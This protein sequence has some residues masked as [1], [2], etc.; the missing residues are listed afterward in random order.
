[1]I[2][3][4]KYKNPNKYIINNNKFIRD[5]ENMY[6]NITDPWCQKQNFEKSEDFIFCL[7]GLLNYINKKKSKISVLDVGAADGILKK[8]LKKKFKYVGTDIHKKKLNDVIY[9]DINILNKSFLN[10]FDVI[11]CLRTIYYVADNIKT[12]IK[13]LKKYLKKNGL[14]I[15]SYNLKKD[16]Y[17]NKYLTDIKLRK[18]LIK[19]FKEKFTIEINRERYSKI[20]GE[21]VTIFIFNK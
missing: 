20:K 21:K 12:V 9:D 11:F 17:S 1:M 5:F 2:K 8:Y 15:I 18:I 7:S 19:N 16:S 13:N 4:K 3:N 6:K 14:L 10:K